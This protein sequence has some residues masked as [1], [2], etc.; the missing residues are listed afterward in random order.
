MAAEVRAAAALSDQ[1]PWP[2]LDCY[3]E[4]AQR[5]FHGRDA[6]SAELLRLV[7]QSPFVLLYGKSGLGKTSMLQAG[8]FPELRQARFLPV[9]LRL[10]YTE[11][12]EQPPLQQA[13]ARVVQAAVD[14]GADVE[15]PE[16]GEGLWSYLQRRER[17]IWTADNY[18]LTPVLVFDQFEEV[19][20][21][22]GSAGHVKQVLDAIADVAGDRF[23]SE[24]AED[25]A[26][27]ERLNLQSQQYRVV[28]SF[29]SDFLADIES[30]ERQANL[31]KHEALHLKAMTPETAVAAVEKAGAAVLEPGVAE[32]IVDFVL[33]RDD[34][35]GGQRA[36][37]VEPV[38][39]SLCCFQ[40]NNRRAPGRRI[41]AALLASAGQDILLD[42]YREALAGTEPRVAHFIQ[43]HLILG[44]RYRA[45]YP[46]DEAL[47]SGA[48][49][50]AELELL[51][52]RRLL[53][54]DPQ[55]DVP[56]I[57]LIHDRI[58]G[59]VNE[60]RQARLAEARLAAERAEAER[61]EAERRSREEARAAEQRAAEAIRRE[62][63]AREREREAARSRNRWR[64][65][66]GA[67]A[68][69]TF[70]VVF[71]ALEASD[72]RREAVSNLHLAQARWLGLQSSGM[73]NGSV[74]GSDALAYQ[75]LLV[76]QALR[77][78]AAD[79]LP[80]FAALLAREQLLRF[81]PVTVVAE[82]RETEPI[83][84]AFLPGPTPRLVVG[85]ADGT[86]TLRDPARPA[87]V[88]ERAQGHRDWVQS[89]AVSPDGTRLVSASQDGTLRRWRTG[90]LAP[91]GEPIPGHEGAAY[92]VAYAPDGSR[93]VSG[94][95]DGW[96]RTWDAAD[97]TMRGGQQPMADRAIYGV[98]WSPSADRPLVVAVT[99][100]GSG[101][102]DTASLI[103]LEPE[104]LVSVDTRYAHSSDALAVTIDPRGL[105]TLT[106]GSDATVRMRRIE[107]GG[108]ERDGLRSSW[109][110]DASAEV[111]A[112]AFSPNGRWAASGDA[113][114]EVQLWD[115][116]QGR[117]VG[118][119]LRG[120]EAPVTNVVYS[121]DGR[122]LVSSSEDLGLRVWSLDP[123]WAAAPSTPVRLP[124]DAARV[125]LDAAGTG[126]LVGLAGDR[127]GLLDGGSA[128]RPLDIA[129]ATSSAGPA[130]PLMA[131][132]TDSAPAQRKSRGIS[133]YPG[134]APEEAAPGRAPA[135]GAA[136]LAAVVGERGVT[137]HGDG[138]LRRWLL[139][140]GSP[141]GAPLHVSGC[142]LEAVALSADG[143]FVA[144]ADA[145]RQM[146][147]LDD[148]GRVVMRPPADRERVVALAVG[149]GGDALV[150]ATSGLG[151]RIHRQRGGTP[152]ELPGLVAPASS[153][154]L[155]PDGRHLVV[156]TEAGT[157]QFWDLE[158]ARP[159]GEPQFVH[160]GA[161][162][163]VVFDAEGRHVVAT[164]PRGDRRAWPAPAGWSAGLCAKL[165]HN[166]SRRQWA[167][168]V[169]TGEPYRCL[170]PG[171]PIAPDDPASGQASETCPAAR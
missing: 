2:G 149:T 68:V 11:G 54:V 154:A 5:Y 52:Q 98:A 45:S 125:A 44:G 39:L 92:S 24:L 60:G 30:W 107:A 124:R 110:A 83:A 88:I 162:Q 151:L 161:V 108:G 74:A 47:A 91:E 49:T 20:S 101:P 122:W 159:L 41:D 94:G 19:F 31:P 80:V 165:D 102:R 112:V 26:S 14:A 89:I 103:L 29:R 67:L 111:M 113:A 75:Q 64:W 53:R 77:P 164:G 61:A 169:P 126:G 132:S 72:R 70:G 17:P 118:L 131:C 34:A 106:G 63:E 27:A 115:V 152:Q 90:P 128:L 38:L 71:F 6:D 93:F 18:P 33:D 79:E 55:G 148:R 73:L 62:Q 42:F 130:E 65:A 21:R 104:T 134:R 51:T 10:D 171:L 87:Q 138:W 22:G 157:M 8:V 166:P 114:G 143:R 167:E 168:W 59:L 15:P 3:T 146:L 129:S 142:A 57:E 1:N 12:A 119:P 66:M 99:S 56:R 121:P 50:K 58:V 158:S 35:G 136:P 76:A 109:R 86:L 28:L 153:L 9:Y 120:A 97:G 82:T 135:P 150:V 147:V 4:A 48:L 96:V 85:H 25:P 170:C 123:Q 46:R 7:R 133:A 144:V 84:L 23:S 127:L 69:M 37:E 100:A 145:D 117:P 140:S 16:P 139:P 32:R 81:E 163:S 40:L 36:T 116:E 43:D 105:S 13:L 141:A 156:G 160:N 78:D 137:A 95:E 155:S